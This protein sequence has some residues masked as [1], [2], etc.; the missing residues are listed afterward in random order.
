MLAVEGGV[1]TRP[2]LQQP[3]QRARLHPC[4]FLQPLGRATGGG[5]E[6]DLGLLGAAKATMERTVKLLP[7]PG[8]PVRMATFRVSASCTAS[9]CSGASVAPSLLAQ[10]AQRRLP[11]DGM[12]C[13]QAILGS[14][15]QPQQA[16]RQGDLGAI[17]GH[18]IDGVELVCWIARLIRF[19]WI[20]RLAHDATL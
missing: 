16:V 6:N 12:K 2:Q 19:T 13:A 5:G 7:Q 18:E 11:V 9:T 3:M 15:Q 1:A 10:P 4:Q 14:A 8:P 17:E 20:E